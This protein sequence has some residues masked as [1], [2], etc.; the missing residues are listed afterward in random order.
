M[1]DKELAACGVWHHASCHGENALRMFQIIFYAVCGKF[2]F[3]T[4]AGT[5]HSCAFRIPSLDHESADH[6]V[7]DQTV[8]EIF[9]DETD[10]II[11]GNGSNIGIKLSLDHVPVFH[12]KCYDRILLFKFLQLYYNHNISIVSKPKGHC[13]VKMRCVCGNRIWLSLS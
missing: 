4:V 10:E 1:H 5:T 3:N 7:E 9:V 11:D 6:A 13:N 2:A 12:G 8:I